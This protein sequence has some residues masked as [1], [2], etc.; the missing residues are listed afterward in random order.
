MKVALDVIRWKVAS[1]INLG[2]L[3][4]RSLSSSSSG[5]RF[6][7]LGGVSLGVGMLMAREERALPRLGW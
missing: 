3:G 1:S 5:S 6:G 7:F 4:S 2:A